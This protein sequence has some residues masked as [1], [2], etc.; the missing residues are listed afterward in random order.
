M[1]QRDSLMKSKYNKMLSGVPFLHY[2]GL[3]LKILPRKD[4]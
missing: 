2:S 1:A 3:D 4:A